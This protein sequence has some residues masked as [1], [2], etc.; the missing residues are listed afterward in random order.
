MFW[1]SC[2]SNEQPQ[3]SSP[4]FP[5]RS[6]SHWKHASKA[7]HRTIILASNQAAI[8]A[9]HQPVIW[10]SQHPAIFQL[11]PRSN[12]FWT[13]A[14]FLWL[15][16]SSLESTGRTAKTSA[17]IKGI[18]GIFALYNL[19]AIHRCRGQI[20][21]ATVLCQIAILESSVFD[22]MAV[23]EKPPTPDRYG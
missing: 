12:F 18:S 8:L 21:V 19:F 16:F 7:A 15:G 14:S 4:R 1:E 23:K 10:T 2:R 22:H 17:Q 11:T 3:D 9:S 6:G 13:V 20:Q 5:I